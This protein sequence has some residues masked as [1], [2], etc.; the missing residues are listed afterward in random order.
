MTEKAYRTIGK[1]VTREGS[2]GNFVKFNAEGQP[3]K[4]GN[5]G[6]KYYQGYLCW[7]DDKTQ[8]YYEVKQA[9]VGSVTDNQKGAGFIDSFFI[10]LN[11]SYDVK[12]M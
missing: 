4:D 5:R 11:N 12:P 1:T 3:D 7:F 2:Q 9:S 8:K 6:G 10:D